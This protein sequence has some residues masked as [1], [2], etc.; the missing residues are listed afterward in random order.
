MVVRCFGAVGVGNFDYEYEKI[1][2][3]G[4]RIAANHFPDLKLGVVGVVSVL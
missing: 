1:C 4:N 2:G 3:F